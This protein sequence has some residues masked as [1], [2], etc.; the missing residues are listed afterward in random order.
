MAG[1]VRKVSLDCSGAMGKRG[2]RGEIQGGEE[3]E[4]FKEFFVEEI[5][6]MLKMSGS[7]QAKGENFV[8]ALFYYRSTE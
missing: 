1:S 8:N 2:S 3:E 5:M 7:N 6:P 4:R